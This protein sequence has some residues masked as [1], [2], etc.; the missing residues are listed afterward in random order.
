MSKSNS[1]LRV[2]QQF[3]I[4]KRVLF[5]LVITFWRVLVFYHIHSPLLRFLMCLA[6]IVVWSGDRNWSSIDG[7]PRYDIWDVVSFQ[8]LGARTSS[9]PLSYNRDVPTNQDEEYD[10]APSCNTLNERPLQP[11]FLEHIDQ[12]ANWVNDKQ[13]KYM[14]T[15]WDELHVGDR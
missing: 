13:L 1:M 8:Q 10:H 15:D 6:Y 12:Y 4:C 5:M 2:F 9:L 3:G 11:F 7:W 14:H